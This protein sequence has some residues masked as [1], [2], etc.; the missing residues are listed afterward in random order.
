M[1]IDVGGKRIGVALSDPLQIIATPVA[2]IHRQNLRR[3]LSEIIRFAEEEEV[4]QIIV[5]N[6]ISM[7]GVER[8]QAHLVHRFCDALKQET[9]IPILLWDERLSTV[10]AE[11]R[12]REGGA[13]ARK[14]S[15]MIDSAAAAVLLQSYLDSSGLRPPQ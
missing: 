7:D 2:V 15:E 5:G 4:K 6:P 9:E 12:L 1:A 14:R 13:S 3:D 8:D 10:E 11:R